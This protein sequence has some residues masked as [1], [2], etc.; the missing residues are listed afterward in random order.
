M[1]NC[2]NWSF[3]SLFFIY[4]I[5]IIIS[6]LKKVGYPIEIKNLIREFSPENL[7]EIRGKKQNLL[8]FWGLVLVHK[9]QYVVQV[10]QNLQCCY[11][12]GKLDQNISLSSPT[13]TL[14]L[15]LH[16]FCPMW[17]ET[18]KYG[19]KYWFKVIHKRMQLDAFIQS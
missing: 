2:K 4:I 10:P 3:L 11:Q 19:L 14:L 9:Q 1:L 12:Q 18:S 16:E 15:L 5:D 7:R 17:F 13:K 6:T 8:R